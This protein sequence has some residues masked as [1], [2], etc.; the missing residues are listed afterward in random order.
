MLGLLGIG[1]YNALQYMALRTSTPLNVTLI[2]SSIPVW[3]M[4]IGA[5]VYGVIPRRAQL[6]GATL[7]LSGVALVLS[8]GEFSSLRN[9]QFVEGDLLVLLAILGWSFYSW[10]LVRPPAHMRGEQRPDWN[11]AEF[12]LAQCLFGVGW[13][14]GSVAVG[15]AIV[16]SAAI[17]W[18]WLLA[19]G[20]LYMA[21]G[22]SIVAYRVCALALT[23]AG[24]TLAAIF[25]NL[26]PV[27]A[28]I[29]SAL[30]I[31]EWP[32]PYHGAAF[33]LILAGIVVSSR[34]TA[35]SA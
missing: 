15:E 7:S 27:F 17:Q 3:T 13:A 32:Q 18:S 2:A 11:W 25:Y 14:L 9:I 33:V 28:A 34:A 26:N 8:R 21:I 29:L 35:K 4:L 19:L 1:V 20:I 10:M 12:L 22:P 16:P 6:V 24:P 23:E 31:G 30:V 5:L